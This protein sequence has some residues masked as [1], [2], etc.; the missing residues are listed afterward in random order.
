MFKKIVAVWLMLALLTPTAF[1]SPVIAQEETTASS[2]TTTV[3]TTD[4][5]PVCG[6]DNKNYSNT[7]NANA[8]GVDVSY[9]GKC[10]DVN[11]TINQTEDT[12]EIQFVGM[13]V[14]IGSTDLPTTIIVRKNGT[15]TDYTV[16]LDNDTIFGQRKDQSTKLADWIPGDQIR[17]IG[18]KNENTDTIDATIA[19]DHSI[20]T[21]NNLGINGWITKIDKTTKEISYNW[22]N[23]EHKFKYD[24]NTKFVAGLKNPATVDDLKIND[25]VRGRL[26]T[27]TGAETP[28]AKIV[29]VLRRGADLFMKIRTFVPEGTLVR[30]DSTVVPTTLQIKI[31]KTPGLRSGDVNNLIGTEGTLVTVNVTENTEIV[32]KYF[33]KT[34]LAEL[35]IGDKLHIVGR[36]NDDNTIDAKLIK[37]ESIWKTNTAGYAGVVTAI[38]SANK[39]LTVNWTPVKHKAQFELKKLLHPEE[40]EKKSKNN[41][42]EGTVTAQMSDDN[43]AEKQEKNNHNEENKDQK[44]STKILEKFLKVKLLE[45]IKKEVKETVGNFVRE[46]QHKKVNIDRIKHPDLELKDLIKREETKKIQV[47]VNDQTVIVVGTNNHAT[48]A[49]VKV[50]D[51]VRIRGVWQS[52]QPSVVAETIVVVSSLPEIEESITTSVDDVNEVVDVIS[53]NTQESTATTTEQEIVTEN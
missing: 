29:V 41:K 23:T 8:A 21:S 10:K 27:R 49:D 20:Q 16:K 22:A 47:V 30:L 26:L 13:L 33:G 18:V 3:C 37:D 34:T 9:E 24:D 1:I 42:E 2:S 44:K 52:N 38:D 46:T 15:T 53:T 17:V 11:Q 25:R 4:Y 7:C 35:S 31:E 19:I 28:T 14:E 48:L 32:R 50:G 12:T 36:V 39:T 45:K 43:N 5:V 51:K 40:K 6:T